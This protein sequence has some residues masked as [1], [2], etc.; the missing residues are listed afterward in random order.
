MRAPDAID[1]FGARLRQVFECHS[2]L[3]ALSCGGLTLTYAE[4]DYRAGALARV[5]AEAGVV[6]GDCIPLF[7]PRSINL[8]VAQLAVLRLG[9]IYAPIDM[10]SPAERRALM[11]E[12]LQARLCIAENPAALPPGLELPCID[13]EAFEP[14]ASPVRLEWSAPPE[15]AAAYV[16]FTSGTT[17]APKG[18]LVPRSGILRLVQDG[19][20]GARLQ[21]GQRW[22]FLSSPAFDASTLEVWAPLFNGGCCVVQEQPLPSI[23]TLADFL[24]GERIDATWLT[25]SLFN[26]CVDLRPDA[27]RG[28]AQVLTGGERVSP[29]HARALL[30]RYPALHL[31][32]G[33]GPTENTTFTLCHTISLADCDDPAGI[34]VGQAIKGTV[35]RIEGDGECGELLAGGDGLAFGYLNN[36][37]QTE[38]KFVTAEGCRWYKTGDLVRR[39]SDGV[40][41]FIGRVDHQVKIQGHRV[42]LEEI[43]ALL[44]RCEGVGEAAVLLVG[45]EAISRHLVA[46]YSADKALAPPDQE[47]VFA[48]L[49]QHL[50]PPAVPRILLRV[51]QMPL[52][53]NGKVD[54][55]ALLASIAQEAQAPAHAAGAGFISETEAALAA[56]WQACLHKASLSREADFWALGGT[57]VLALQLS[58]QIGRHFSKDFPPVEILRHPLLADQARRL[59]ALPVVCRALSEVDT[60]LYMPLSESQHMLL[61]LVQDGGHPGIC[62]RRILLRFAAAHTPAEICRAFHA[63]AELHPSL[64]L[65][66]QHEGAAV[67]AVVQAHWPEQRCVIH[68]PPG[69]TPEEDAAGFDAL[70][71]ACP[72]LDPFEHGLMLGNCWPFPDGS[73]LFVWTVHELAVDSISIEHCLDQ[74]HALLSG[75]TLAPPYGAIAAFPALEQSW[76]DLARIGL[77]T[78]AILERAHEIAPPRELV[79][80]AVSRSCRISLATGLS[81]RLAAICEARQAS[82]AV[83]VLVAWSNALQAVLRFPPLVMVSCSRRLE[84]ELIEPVGH[85]VEECPV[86]AAQGADESLEDAIE[87]VRLAYA[88]HAG[89]AG[90]GMRRV[91]AALKDLSVDVGRLFRSFSFCWENVLPAQ[92]AMGRAACSVRELPGMA[93]RYGL[94][95]KA[96]MVEGQLMFELTAAEAAC[97][98]GLVAIIERAF[99]QQLELVCQG[100]AGM[101]AGLPGSGAQS[102]AGTFLQR[103]WRRH[104]SNDTGLSSSSGNFLID[105]GSIRDALHMLVDLRRLYGIHLDVG[106]FLSC[107]SISNLTRM[108]EPHAAQPSAA[109]EIVGNARASRLLVL[110]PGKHGGILS[111]Y[112]LATLIQASLGED[113]ALVLIDFDVLLEAADGRNAMDFLVDECEVRLRPLGVARIAGIIGYSLGGLLALHLAGRLSGQAPAPVCMLDTYAPSIYAHTSPRRLSW[114][115]ANL[116]FGSS[117]IVA[118]KLCFGAFKKFAPLLEKIGPSMALLVRG[119]APP[120]WEKW[121]NPRTVTAWQSLHRLLSREQ[122]RNGRIDVTLLVA[123]L[124]LDTFGVLWRRMS[125]G[126][127]PAW[128]RSLRIQR[129]PIQH[130]D[131]THQAVDKV[132]ECVAQEFARRLRHDDAAIR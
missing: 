3:P 47:A 81:S 56:I 112:R 32:N 49:A 59:D 100:E 105:G 66:L 40:H 16:M 130:D 131:I 60:G 58:A 27:F 51:D 78:E 6:R 19:A 67:N 123:T 29:H 114:I 39:R 80:P 91:E 65:I 108:V 113:V 21:P 76:T 14:G 111:I 103:L 26:I 46:F 48:S 99:R 31:I 8:V 104:L 92:R 96:S 64:R 85:L 63:L 42:E 18:V 79:V 71:E 116:L 41:E 117:R 94:M 38:R 73:V 33:Y 70:I 75:E 115:V 124:S 34:P 126:F 87:R 54:R 121:V 50:P 118:A 1:A 44:T 36:S 55:K 11:L 88:G 89:P 61:D 62:Q 109:M 129:M 72:T 107:P 83:L 25:A 12:V 13:L 5:L 128:F 95:L 53:A 82:P 45:D 23:D 17:G 37:E 125:N 90:S 77:V 127:N 68:D 132:A 30:E 120:V 86:F 97:D 35:V 69:F 15:P 101:P 57:S 2:T 106:R 110:L 93:A 119:P 43:E 24:I 98:S 9:A 22:G 102:D 84:P 122:A 74:L 4:L 20:C 52:N 10:A 28:L 7:V